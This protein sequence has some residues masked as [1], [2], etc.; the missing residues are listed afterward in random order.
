V[1]IGILGSGDVGQSLGRG[2]AQY[3]HQVM[4]GSREPGQERVRKWVGQVGENGSAGS[5]AEAAAF[6]ELVVLATHW[7]GTQNA[8]ALAGV[9]RLAAKTLIDATNPL[10]FSQGQPRLVV[11]LD[12]SGGEQ[13][14]RWLPQSRVVKAFNTVGH[15]HMVDPVF[16]GGP[17]DMFICGNDPVAKGTVSG[18]LEELGWSAIDLGEIDCARYLEPMAMV[19]IRHYLNTGNGNHAFKLLRA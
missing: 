11:G 4:M 7:S 2:F 5:S 10:D 6:G 18:L 12:D 16:A 15:A 9:E 14:Q 19:W 17:P 8:L 1:R 13:V 3:G